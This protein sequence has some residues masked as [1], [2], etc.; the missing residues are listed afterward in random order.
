VKAAVPV[1]HPRLHVDLVPWRGG[2]VGRSRAHEVSPAG[3]SK[4][5]GGPGRPGLTVFA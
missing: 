1:R 3:Q 2:R 5:S 4:Q